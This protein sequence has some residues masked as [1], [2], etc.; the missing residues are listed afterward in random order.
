VL[1]GD[2]VYVMKIVDGRLEFGNSGKLPLSMLLN[3]ANGQPVPYANPYRERN[4]DVDVTAEFKKL[5][6]PLMNW[7]LGTKDFTNAPV[8]ATS[9]HLDLFF[10]ARSPENFGISG[11]QFGREVGY[12]LYH[13]DLFKPES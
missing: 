10:F 11:P 9:G 6:A 7:S 5:A 2:Q 8:S 12:V 4:Q 1:Q 3:A 13:L